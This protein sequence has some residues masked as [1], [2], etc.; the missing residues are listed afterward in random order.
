M[1]DN[2]MNEMF[3][4][5][6]EMLANNQVPDEFKSIV[7][8]FQKSNSNNNYNPNPKQTNNN[9]KNYNT[10]SQMNNRQ[11]SSSNSNNSMPDI[12]MAT[13]MKMQSIM[14]KMKSSDNDDMSRLLLSLK[15]YLRDEKKDKIDEYI[16]LIKM[17]RLTQVIESLGGDKR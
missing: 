6:K 13:L 7:S 1:N 17:G 2:D 14:S 11:T 12:D 4:K 8:N 9:Q 3:N 10:Y 15:P 16:K 5:A